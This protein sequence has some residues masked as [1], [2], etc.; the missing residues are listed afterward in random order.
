MMLLTF[1]LAASAVALLAPAP[2]T[3]AAGG[4]CVTFCMAPDACGF[5]CCY[6]TCCGSSCFDLDCP[7]PCDGN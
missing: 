7:P 6:Q 4:N 3:A 1:A 5:V 2:A